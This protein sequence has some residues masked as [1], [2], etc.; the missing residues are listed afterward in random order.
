ME[1]RA[2]PRQTV[3]ITVSLSDGRNISGNIQIDLDTRLSD[4]MNYP[5]R[6]IIISDKDKTLKIYDN[7]ETGGI[8]IV[9]LG[10]ALAETHGA[11]S[12]RI[13]PVDAVTARA[14]IAEVPGLARGGDAEVLADAV[15]AVSDLARVT[16]PRVAEAEINPLIVKA[17]GA[18]AVD[19][20]IVLSVTR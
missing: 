4:F 7:P 5:E 8:V 9:G 14:M 10:G 11:V 20:L 3:K 15:A 6:F 12:I 2:I 18:V 17:S 13:S 19:G 16:A 1:D